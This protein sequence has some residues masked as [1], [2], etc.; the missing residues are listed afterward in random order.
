MKSNFKTKAN[1]SEE[2]ECIYLC[3]LNYANIYLHLAND[4]ASNILHQKFISCWVNGMHAYTSNINQ[5]RKFSL[6][7]FFPSLL[8]NTIKSL[9]WS[10]KGSF[11]TCNDENI[12]R[13]III[14]WSKLYSWKR[15]TFLREQIHT[16]FFPTF[17]A[18]TISERL[19]LNTLT[20]ARVKEAQRIYLQSFHCDDFWWVMNF[21]NL[22][23]ENA[24]AADDRRK[25]MVWELKRH[26]PDEIVNQSSNG[27]RGS[28][29]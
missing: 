20:F 29:V 16:Q 19:I 8:F 27:H 15:C 18:F 7:N 28:S 1:T 21:L 22:L 25:R 4:K 12:V 13:I 5:T 24:A 14:S 26:Q 6:F 3:G 9:W 11:S 23:H 10:N 17:A 2:A